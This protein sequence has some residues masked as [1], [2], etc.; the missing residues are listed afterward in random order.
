[1]NL[2][3]F[4]DG[5]ARMIPFS[6]VSGG[7][8]TAHREDLE[9]GRTC[10]SCEQSLHR[11]PLCGGEDEEFLCPKCGSRFMVFDGIL[12]FVDGWG[13]PLDF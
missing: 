12:R 7:K 8:V 5:E 6:S 10:L 9:C 13:K 4:D 2:C 1:M 3:I 11:Y